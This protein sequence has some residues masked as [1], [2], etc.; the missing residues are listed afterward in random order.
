MLSEMQEYEVNFKHHP[1][2]SLYK[3]H[4]VQK[5]HNDYLK[6]EDIGQKIDELNVGSLTKPVLNMTIALEELWEWVD[7]PNF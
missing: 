7:H 2:Y 6:N 1:W 5:F 4:W 3:D